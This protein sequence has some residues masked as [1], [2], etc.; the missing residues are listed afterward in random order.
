ML[1]SKIQEQEDQIKKLKSEEEKMVN[2]IKEFKEA[3]KKK[4]I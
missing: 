2:Y 3:I 4:K 1:Q